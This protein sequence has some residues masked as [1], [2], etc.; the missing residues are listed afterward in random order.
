[1]RIVRFV[2]PFHTNR[3]AQDRPVVLVDYRG[4]GRS[5]GEAPDSVQGMARDIIAFIRTLGVEQVD[6]FAFSLGGFVAQQVV[7]DAP[8][9]VRRLILA[10]TGPSG[11]E[12]MAVYTPQVQEIVGRPNST[13]AERGVGAVLRTDRH[14]PGCGQGLD[15]P[16]L[17]AAGR[18][19]A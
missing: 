14:E 8:E 7:L 5:T 10:G 2:R 3:F 18:P 11:G 6:L 15:R 9:R 12:G 17:R 13:P 1:M 19:G 4:V 16:H